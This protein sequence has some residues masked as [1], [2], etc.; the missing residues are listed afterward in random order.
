M[1]SSISGNEGLPKSKK[2]TASER[3]SVTVYNKYACMHNVLSLFLCVRTLSQKT[4]LKSSP[5][6][7]FGVFCPFS[8]VPEVFTG[9]LLDPF[10]AMSVVK[11][12]AL[13]G[14]LCLLGLLLFFF[15]LLQ[16]ATEVPLMVC[17][18]WSLCF[19]PPPLPPSS[20][21]SRSK[22]LRRAL[23]ILFLLRS[24]VGENLILQ[25]V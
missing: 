18:R 12:G 14:V 15:F 5:F 17:E 7:S 8:L 19:V 1:L 22:R 24:S 6:L 10:F 3:K 2:P 13:L 23:S 25:S 9:V 4:E 20:P 21:P 16:S 11:S